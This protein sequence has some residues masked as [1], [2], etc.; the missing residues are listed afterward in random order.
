MGEPGLRRRALEQLRRRR[1]GD[2]RPTDSR[3]LARYG[4]L[5]VGWTF[6]TAAFGIVLSLRY[7]HVLATLVPGP[8]A[9]ALIAPVWAALLT[10]PLVVL[11]PRK[12]RT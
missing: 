1:A 11:L 6:A 3:L 5:A 8:A 12:A 10:L 7:E 4:L 2:R 9:W